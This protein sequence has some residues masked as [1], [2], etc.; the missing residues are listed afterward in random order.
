DKIKTENNF[1][2]I[3]NILEEK[4]VI[5]GSKERKNYEIKIAYNSENE[6]QNQKL[7]SFFRTDIDFPYP[8]MAHGTFELKSSRDQLVHDDNGFNKMLLEKLAFLLIK[9]A[10][11][12]TK[13]GQSSYDALSMVLPKQ[14]QYSGLDN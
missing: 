13:N 4:G 2:K 8:V 10:L 11:E 14:G 9:G 7:Y 5:A 6:I 3:W 1:I 12:I